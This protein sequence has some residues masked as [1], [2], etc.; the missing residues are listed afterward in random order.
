[1]GELLNKKEK[2]EHKKHFSWG[3]SSKHIWLDLMGILW[4]YEW[5]IKTV[6]STPIFKA[7]S[8]IS[9]RPRTLFSCLCLHVCSSV[10]FCL[11][12]RRRESWDHLKRHA[13]IRRLVAA[14]LFWPVK[15]ETRTS[16][17]SVPVCLAK[18]KTD[19]SINWKP[20]CGHRPSLSR[21]KA[22]CWGYF[23][24]CF[25]PEMTSQSQFV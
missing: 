6:K 5:I 10:C 24:S 2:N 11:I 17:S 19:P 20:R 18:V 14:S 23:I 7:L 13:H 15:N 4:W 9:Q 21:P 3:Y 8:L 25:A 22:F 16:W 1:M 12:R